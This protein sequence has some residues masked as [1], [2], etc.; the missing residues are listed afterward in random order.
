MTCAT[1]SG[2]KKTVPKNESLSIWAVDG[3]CESCERLYGLTR[4]HAS[5]GNEYNTAAPAIKSFEPP[6]PL[7]QTRIDQVIQPL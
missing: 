5:R 1:K 2:R 7:T 6:S 4:S 3:A